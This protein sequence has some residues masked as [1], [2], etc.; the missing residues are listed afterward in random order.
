MKLEDV[1]TLR[2]EGCTKRITLAI[3]PEAKENLLRLKKLKR[4]DP[5]ELV[6]MLIDNFFR[7][8]PIDEAG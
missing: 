6:R 8:N 3:T 2:A 5:S 7:D 1:P 4:R